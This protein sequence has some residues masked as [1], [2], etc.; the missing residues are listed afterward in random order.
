MLEY[1]RPSILEFYDS[2]L[3]AM[4]AADRG[5][6]VM[7]GLKLFLGSETHKMLTDASLKMWYFSPV[8]I[9]DMWENEVATGNPR[10]SFYIC[11]DEI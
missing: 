6:S 3:S 9:F 7:E 4:I 10:N 8:A 11:G 5:I 1:T 2:E